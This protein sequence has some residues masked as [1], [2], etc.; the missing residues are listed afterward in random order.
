MSILG[1]VVPHGNVTARFQA[2]GNA[3]RVLA[4]AQPL[5]EV[6]ART[7]GDLFQRECIRRAK[8]VDGVCE[9]GV[10]RSTRG[11]DDFPKRLRFGWRCAV[12]GV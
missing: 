10:L 5:T 9:L 1:T 11:V 12:N 2:V 3:A 6:V 7:A 4:I 8:G